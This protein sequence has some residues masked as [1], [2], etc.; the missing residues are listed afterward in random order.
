MLSKNPL[1]MDLVFS[2]NRIIP[3]RINVRVEHVKHSNCRKEFV[4]RVKNNDML[5]KEAKAKGTHV[6][7][8]RIVSILLM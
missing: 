1:F 2:R 3:K 6:V 8:K 7:C 5:M 4:D